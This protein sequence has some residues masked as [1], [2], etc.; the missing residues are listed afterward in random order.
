MQDCSIVN[1][2]KEKTVFEQ[3]TG[4]LINILQYLQVDILNTGDVNPPYEHVQSPVSLVVVHAVIVI[5]V[6]SV[7]V[8]FGLLYPLIVV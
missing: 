4:R 7:P 5:S 3:N 6:M 2:Y 8:R 1:I